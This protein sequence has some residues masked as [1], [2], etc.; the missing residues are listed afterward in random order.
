[1][2]VNKLLKRFIIVFIVIMVLY[3]IFKISLGF[4]ISKSRKAVETG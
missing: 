2:P 3:I 1:M 4:V